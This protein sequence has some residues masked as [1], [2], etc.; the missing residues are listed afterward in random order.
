MATEH[1]HSQ[2]AKINTSGVI[3]DSRKKTGE[4]KSNGEL[5]IST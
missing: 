1:T 2:N 4:F 3:L 5:G